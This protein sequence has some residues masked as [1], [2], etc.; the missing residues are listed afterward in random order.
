MLL[1][2]LHF[3]FLF[4]FSFSQCLLTVIV[5]V[6][7]FSVNTIIVKTIGAKMISDISTMHIRWYHVLIVWNG[8]R[9][10]TSMYYIRPGNIIYSPFFV[11]QIFN[12][13]LVTLT[14]SF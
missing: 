8:L 11:Y 1:D 5:S 7:I 10:S 13:F 9:S 4:L 14:I 12:Y 2:N 6:N 3:S